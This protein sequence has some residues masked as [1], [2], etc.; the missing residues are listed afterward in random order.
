M[1]RTKG[2]D[3]RDVARRAMKQFWLHGYYATS[4]DHLVAATGVS[5]HG[6]YSEFRDKRGLFVD[7]VRVYCDEVVT[8]AFCQVEA[9]GAGTTQIR[10]FL[11]MQIDRADAAGLPGPGCMMANLMVE[12]GPH[13]KEFGALVSTHLSRLTSGFKSAISNEQRRGRLHDES[14]ARDLALHLTIATQGLWSVSRVVKEGDVLRAYADDLV[15]QIEE[16]VRT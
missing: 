14:V 1:G 5:R 3:K 9:V 15:N 4:I 10:A 7:T 11:K 6:L 8:P 12:A 13:D 16:K 2:Y